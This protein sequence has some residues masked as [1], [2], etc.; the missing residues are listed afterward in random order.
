MRYVV[1]WVVVVFFAFNDGV[2]GLKDTSLTSEENTLHH[3]ITKGKNS[4][5][6]KRQLRFNVDVDFNENF[7]NDETGADEE[8]GVLSRVLVYDKP[9]KI[10]ESLGLGAA[11]TQKQLSK[12]L[13][14]CRAY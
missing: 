14:Y 3:I 6:A 11:I 13:K 7:E 4:V 5:V 1:F 8:R 10:F 9:D 12:W 2:S